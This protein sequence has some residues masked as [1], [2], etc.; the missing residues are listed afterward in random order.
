[1]ATYG[2]SSDTDPAELA[3]IRPTTAS[4]PPDNT[5]YQGPSYAFSGIGAVHQPCPFPMQP[6]VE[7]W[8]KFEQAE[9]AMNKLLQATGE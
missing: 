4:L 6:Y 2:S 7:A 9:A 5:T 3:P 1:M 8:S